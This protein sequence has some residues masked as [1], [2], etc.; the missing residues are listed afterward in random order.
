M[1][2]ATPGTWQIRRSIATET[3]HHLKVWGVAF[4]AVW[5]G[6]QILGE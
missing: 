5:L 2:Q 1:I 3:Q 4:I 6:R